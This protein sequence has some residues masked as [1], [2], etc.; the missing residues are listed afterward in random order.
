MKTVNA[1]SCKY[2]KVI[3]VIETRATKGSGTENDPTREVI[4]YW[5]LDGKLLTEIDDQPCND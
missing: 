2:A 1:S 4:Q 3:Q 5:H